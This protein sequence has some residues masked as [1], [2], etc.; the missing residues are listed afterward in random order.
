MLG[1]EAVGATDLA[2]QGDD[3]GAHELDDPSA[4]GADEVV[5]ALPA[6]HVFIEVVVTTETVLGHQASVDQEIKVAI[7]GGARDVHPRSQ[8]RGKEIFRVDVTMLGEDLLENRQPLGGEPKAIG[9]EV[10]EELGSLSVQRH[11]P[12]PY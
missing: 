4:R 7:D 1:R 12:D 6:V 8:Q 2:L 3:A 10:L 5:V 11:V 9:L